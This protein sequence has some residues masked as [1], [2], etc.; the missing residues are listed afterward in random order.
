MNDIL[1]HQQLFFL[2]ILQKN[3]PKDLATA[4]ASAK[5]EKDKIVERG[6]PKAHVQEETKVLSNITQR[7]KRKARSQDQE[8]PFQGTTIPRTSTVLE[9]AHLVKSSPSVLQLQSEDAL[10]ADCDSWHHPYCPDVKT[11]RCKLGSRC[12]SIHSQRKRRSHVPDSE[13]KGE[14]E[15]PK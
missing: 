6:R 14:T 1:E 5:K 11:N 4:A 12:P 10:M 8:A 9:E 7:R 13:T 2:L 3:R 15:L